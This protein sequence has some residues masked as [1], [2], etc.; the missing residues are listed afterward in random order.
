M[1]EFEIS[2]KSLKEIETSLT[3]EFVKGLEGEG[4]DVKVKM[5]NTCVHSMPDG[6]EEGDFLV[7]NLGGRNLRVLHISE[8]TSSD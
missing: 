5:L 1:G 8:S 4:D 6:K 3:N 2:L 7:I